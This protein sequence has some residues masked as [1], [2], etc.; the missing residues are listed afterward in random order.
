MN[1]LFV[2]YLVVI[3]SSVYNVFL[4]NYGNLSPSLMN[5]YI[6]IFFAQIVNGVRFSSILVDLI[7]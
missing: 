5:Q 6:N 4:S 3:D 1:N 7:L 2:E